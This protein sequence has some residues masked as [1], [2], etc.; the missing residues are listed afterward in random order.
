MTDPV[1]PPLRAQHAGNALTIRVQI[2]QDGPAVI[3]HVTLP[4]S[5]TKWGD[6]LLHAIASAVGLPAVE[7]TDVWI[8]YDD[9][10][11]T[12]RVDPTAARASFA[13]IKQPD[14][15][16]LVR[17]RSQCH[18]AA[19]AALPPVATCQMNVSISDEEQY[20]RRLTALL[21]SDPCPVTRILQQVFIACFNRKYP[22]FQWDDTAMVPPNWKWGD[23]DPD[24]AA[25]ITANHVRKYA[26]LLVDRAGS[27]SFNPIEL[28]YKVQ[29]K[30]NSAVL[31]IQPE[32]DGSL[33]RL[34]LYRGDCIRVADPRSPQGYVDCKVVG[35]PGDRSN[36]GPGDDPPN[37]I[38][39]DVK[40]KGG[41][42]DDCT[43][44][45]QAV[46]PPSQVDT[47]KLNPIMLA[48]QNK[49]AKNKLLNEGIA[50][51]DIT[52]LHALLTTGDD[53]DKAVGGVLPIVDAAGLT[54]T[55][56]V[57]KNGKNTLGSHLVGGRVPADQ[58]GGVM[59][60]VLQLLEACRKSGLLDAEQAQRFEAT[61][62]MIVDY[63]YPG[64]TLQDLVPREGH[65]AD[66]VYVGAN[67][68]K[69]LTLAQWTLF[70]QIVSGSI[71]SRLSVQALAGS[72]KTLLCQELA[73]QFLK[74]Q[75]HMPTPKPYRFLLLVHSA[76]LASVCADCIKATAHAKLGIALDCTD[77]D[78][79]GKG[80]VLGTQSPYAR[81]EIHVV[82]IDSVVQAVIGCSKPTDELPEKAL[83]NTSLLGY[84][85]ATAV[86][87]GHLVFSHQAHLHLDGQHLLR[88]CAHVREVVEV[89]MVQG[90]RITVFHD[91]DQSDNVPV[92]Y[93][94][95]LVPVA[96]HLG[97][98]RCTGAVRD[99]SVPS[100]QS[101]CDDGT[102]DVPFKYI[103]LY[104]E[105]NVGPDV[106]LVDVQKP[107]LW[108][109]LA[110][111]SGSGVLAFHD[112]LCRLSDKTS[113][114]RRWKAIAEAEKLYADALYGVL[115][116]IADQHMAAPSDIGWGDVAVVC[117]GNPFHHARDLWAACRR[118]ASGV[119][120]E[121]L[122]TASTT[123][124]ADRDKLYF[125][126]VEN[127]AGLER[128]IVVVTGFWHPHALLQRAP[129]TV[130]SKSDSSVKLL[131][132]VDYRV[133]LAVTRCTHQLWFVEPD[134]KRF[135]AH[136]CLWLVPVANQLSSG[137]PWEGVPSLL[138]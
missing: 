133:Y 76:S 55:L 81:T 109:D 59:A 92:V 27:G 106:E 116:T 135:A 122:K 28:P 20:W 77:G 85:H 74:S 45:R 110:D 39:T 60:A 31:V 15:T 14:V 121:A 25:P 105:K 80:V 4:D 24:P 6:D 111:V 42:R 89:V 96:A 119:V 131:S 88:N 129:G 102:G 130:T 75:L 98:V 46:R 118:K 134:V 113:F 108:R 132:R 69:H 126:P 38:D 94:E 58:F 93:P 62:R 65:G 107:A 53:G 1:Q 123:S 37:E 115:A 70:S 47:G 32:P 11:S 50:A 54:P 136:F 43:V 99:A 49:D 67:R 66:A 87:E 63:D 68:I 112:S 2:K 125:G 73:L 36:R 84:F 16:V 91:E 72:G 79:C 104:D 83:W 64:D 33:A 30:A 86:D 114:K 120:L 8:R 97:I 128:P 51:L 127:M 35:L 71:H 13:A 3:H 21:Q 137:R 41:Q 17:P 90:S 29:R 57:V 52:A 56:R 23:P 22:T 7:P 10:G 61:V 78:Y 48:S 117:P 26:R 44:W 100:A 34:N 95:G 124:A 101:L 9:D 18:G 103:G 82:P 12:E 40:N 5:A 138:T 19:A